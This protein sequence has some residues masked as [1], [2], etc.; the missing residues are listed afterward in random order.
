VAAERAI[1]NLEAQAAPGRAIGQDVRYLAFRLRQIF[2][3]FNDSAKRKSVLSSRG[4]GEF[5]QEEAGAFFAF[6]KEVLAPLNRY[7]ASLLNDGEAPKLSAEFITRLAVRRGN[8]QSGG[9]P[10]FIHNFHRAIR[11]QAIVMRSEME[12]AL[13]IELT[14]PSTF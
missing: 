12:T 2:L 10:I 8:G 7:L 13:W 5:C 9:S 6:V 1:A 11:G 3:R 4:D 14:T